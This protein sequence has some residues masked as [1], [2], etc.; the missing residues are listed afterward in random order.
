MAMLVIY[1]IYRR[2]MAV[3]RPLSPL[4]LY[5]YLPRDLRTAPA[6]QAVV[7]VVVVANLSIV[8]GVLTVVMIIRE[9][10]TLRA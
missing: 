5:R 7:V 10:L 3:I 6:S 9:R 8:N 1:L 4:Y 2:L